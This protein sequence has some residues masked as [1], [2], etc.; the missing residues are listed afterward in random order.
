MGAGWKTGGPGGVGVGRTRWALAAG[1]VLMLGCS[2]QNRGIG[3][4]P[5]PSSDAAAGQPIWTATSQDFR[6]NC[7]SS[8]RGS[9]TFLSTRDELSD[10]QLALLA[11]MRTGPRATF[12]SDVLMCNVEIMAKDGN[13]AVYLAA[14]QDG[15]L[16]GSAPVI[17]FASFAPFLKTVPCVFAKDHGPEHPAPPDARCSNG[18]WLESGSGSVDRFLTVTDASAQ[19]VLALDG[20]SDLIYSQS[21]SL[22]VI[23]GADPLGGD[24]PVLTQAAAPPTPGSTKTCLTA[25]FTFPAPGTYRMRVEIAPSLPTTGF[26]D[27]SFRF[28]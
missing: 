25:H 12:L 8:A 19:R 17:T 28:Y 3:N 4:P 27:F 15:V 26:S 11:A 7:R 23:P 9:M 2:S 14:E 16:D 21:L 22:E 20:C 1:I 18:I 5:A 10:Q 6:M 24:P 13:Y